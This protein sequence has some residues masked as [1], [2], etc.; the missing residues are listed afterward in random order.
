M[1]APRTETG[2][3]G[4]DALANLELGTSAD[5]INNG[6]AFKAGKMGQLGQL[7]VSSRNHVKVGGVD[8]RSLELDRHL[9]GGGS[10]NGGFS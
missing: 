1:A 5:G 7:A 8:G 4:N 10:G 2:V 6:N 9:A 3:G